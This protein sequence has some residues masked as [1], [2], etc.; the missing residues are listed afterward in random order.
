[1]RR[2]CW[3]GADHA[4]RGQLVD[5]RDAGDSAASAQAAKYVELIVEATDNAEPAESPRSP[6][7]RRRRCR[8]CARVLGRVERR[9]VEVAASRRRPEIGELD[10]AERLQADAGVL[11]RRE[12]Q[13]EVDLARA[14]GA[15][16]AVDVPVRSGT[17]ASGEVLRRKAFT[18]RGVIESARLGSRPMCNRP[19]GRR[20]RLRARLRTWPMSSWIFS[21]STNRSAASA[22]GRS[23]P[24]M[25]STGESR[26]PT[27]HGPAPCW[28]PAARC[29][30]ARRPC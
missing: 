24:L 26:A 22:V 3:P 15:N 9:Q 7:G 13:R 19:S 5:D 11:A 30:A 29:R 4:R 25:R 21:T 2:R 6:C 17:S 20:W 12:G 14:Q 8:G 1:M 28:R 16:E 23:R 27:R 18:A 10:L